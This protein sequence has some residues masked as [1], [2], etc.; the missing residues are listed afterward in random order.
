MHARQL[1]LV[2]KDIQ[3]PLQDRLHF[4]HKQL[5]ETAEIFL[6]FRRRQA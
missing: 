5:F 4:G 1:Y 3:L 2:M 6:L